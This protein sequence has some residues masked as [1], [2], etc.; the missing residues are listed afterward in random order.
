MNKSLDMTN[1]DRSFTQTDSYEEKYVPLTND[2]SR[3]LPNQHQQ[4][5]MY[6]NPYQQ[7]QPHFAPC[8]TCGVYGHL[9]KN[10]PQQ[11]FAQ[12]NVSN[13]LRNTTKVATP[14]YLHRPHMPLSVYPQAF[15]SNNSIRLTH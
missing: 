13:Y 7:L 14:P 6:G 2:Y 5:Q 4:I 3:P 15:L 11:A 9:S 10:C 12:Q 8:Y 1:P